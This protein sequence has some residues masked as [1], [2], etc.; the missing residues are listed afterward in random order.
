MLDFTFNFTFMKKCVFPISQSGKV[1]FW[2]CGTFM[3]AEI[4]VRRYHVIVTLYNGYSIMFATFRFR[5]SALL[6]DSYF[7]FF[8]E[9]LIDFAQ[10]EPSFQRLLCRMAVSRLSRRSQD[11]LVDSYKCVSELSR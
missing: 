10:F 1:N 6:K 9:G 4:E 11:I 8:M 5:K 2:Y 3:S 7:L